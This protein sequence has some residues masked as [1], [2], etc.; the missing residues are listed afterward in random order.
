M[1]KGALAAR[2]ERLSS[3]RLY[4]GSIGPEYCPGGAPSDAA[5]ESETDSDY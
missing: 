3:P 5:G 2:P 1:K 4:Q